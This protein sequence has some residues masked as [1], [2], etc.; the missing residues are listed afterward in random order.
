MPVNKTVGGPI[1]A[2]KLVQKENNSFILIPHFFD[3]IL[4]KKE[5]NIKNDY[6]DIIIKIIFKIQNELSI[7]SNRIYGIGQSTGADILFNLV[8]NN[9]NLFSSMIIINGI[10]INKEILSSMNTTFIYFVTEENLNAFNVQTEI[11]KFLNKSNIEF[12]SL[13]NVNPQELNQNKNLTNTFDKKYKFN[14]ITFSKIK[15][16]TN[17]IE[18]QIYIKLVRDWLFSQNKIKCNK[19]YYYSEELGKCF[20]KIKKNVFLIYY[21]ESGDIILNLLKNASFI[22]KVTLGSNF[23]LPKMTEEF[24]KQYDCI[25][26][27]LKDAES[28][29]NTQHWD[30]IK[31]YIQSG[32]SFLVTHDRWDASQGP[33]ELIGQEVQ[34]IPYVIGVS[35]R[36]KVSRFGHPIFDSY[37][38]LSDWKTI[39][40][41]RTHISNHKIINQ[42]NNTARVIMELVQIW[43]L[44][45]NWII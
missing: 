23:D 36:A 17:E 18:V 20:S 13:V 42:T 30:D 34:K 12:G 3:N 1:W 11:K 40:V 9:P 45:L 41:A 19:N 24:M 32:G 39:D 10:N 29:I 25:I 43:K 8:T 22:S 26:Y 35:T 37:Y 14:F 38:N 7:D 31:S 44:E 28:P 33:L 27:D 4:D 2:T 16:I 6:L 15:N 5:Q 21:N